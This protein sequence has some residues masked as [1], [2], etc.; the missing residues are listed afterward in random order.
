MNHDAENYKLLDNYISKD[1]VVVDVGGY[2][3]WYTDYFISKLGDT[4]VIYCIEAD[5]GN[6]NTLKNRFRNNTNVIV[7]NNAATNTDGLINLYASK[8]PDMRNI[9]GHDV[10]M[11]DSPLVGQVQGL[12]LD[13]LLKDHPVIDII[14]IDVEGAELQVLEGLQNVIDRVRYILV[15]CHFAKD[16]PAIRHML[17]NEYKLECIHVDNNYQPI[18]PDY[19]ITP[20]QCFCENKI[21]SA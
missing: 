2:K 6:F 20:Y 1:N 7:L 16:W 13:E 9:V 10:R 18:T 14:K 19:N 3:G 5:P 11:H 12:R 4:G 8:E 15:E 21:I 17:L